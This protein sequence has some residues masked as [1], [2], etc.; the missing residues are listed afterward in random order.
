MP[1]S[2]HSRRRGPILAIATAASLAVPAL[3]EDGARKIIAESR[4]EVIN[5]PQQ[6]ELVQLVVDFLPGAWTSWHTHGGQAVNLVLEGEITL[7]HV[8][9][10]QTY[11]AGQAWSDSPG[12]VHAAGNTASGKAR[13]LTNFLLPPGAPQTTAVRDSSFEPAIVY[14]ASFPLPA[15]PAAMQ[16]V[17]QV[18]DLDRGWRTERALAGLTASITLSG[19]VTYKVGGALKLYKAGEAWSAPGNTLVGEENGS[20]ET[21]RVFTTSLLPRDSG[22]Q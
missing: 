16:I 7:R 8:G 19:E 13:L 22:R 14:A 1:N 15:L 2:K 4:F 10:E 9:M 3:G 12:Q 21:A 20:A 18:I 17:Q 5:A 11:R 6:A